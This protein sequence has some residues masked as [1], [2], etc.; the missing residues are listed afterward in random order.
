MGDLT[1]QG[2]VFQHRLIG[3]AVLVVVIAAVVAGVLIFGGSSSKAACTKGGSCGYDNVSAA[4]AVEIIALQ[5]TG[6]GSISSCKPTSGEIT[7]LRGTDS[8]EWDCINAQ[9]L[10][11]ASY[12]INKDG[13]VDY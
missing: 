10:A 2:W 8:S 1:R 11:S 5:T 4:N 9:S 7:A 6:P 12:T 3:L 13:S